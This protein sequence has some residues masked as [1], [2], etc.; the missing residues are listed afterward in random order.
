MKLKRTLQ[1][2]LSILALF[3]ISSCAKDEPS[4]LK[5]FVKSNSNTQVENATVRIVG[6]LSK[7][8]PEHLEERNSNENDVAIFNLD[9]FFSKYS[10]GDG[11]VAYFNVYLKDTVSLFNLV[12]NV[13]VKAN[14]TS[15]MTVYLK[16]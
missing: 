3:L 10:K 8:T 11:K 7:E 14:I 15:T 12:G 13:K 6:D 16:K 1:L 5:V 2:A 4:I 9:D